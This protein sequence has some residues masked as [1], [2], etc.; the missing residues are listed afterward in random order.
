MKRSSTTDREVPRRSHRLR[1]AIIGTAAGLLLG[2]LL[3]LGLFT[4][5][6]SYWRSGP[7]IDGSDPAVAQRA[8]Q[9]EQ[10]LSSQTT[11]VRSDY[12]RWQIELTEEEVNEWLAARLPEWMRN[13]GIDERAVQ[14]AQ[15]A[16]VNVKPGQVELATVV[17]LGKF[18]PVVRLVYKPELNEAGRVQLSLD[19]IYA[20][21]MPLPGDSLIDEVL[22]Q[23]GPLEEEQ[24]RRVD[25]AR[26]TLRD[27][28][29]VLHLGDGRVVSVVGMELREGKVSL[30]CITAPTAV[31]S[32]GT[33]DLD[34]DSG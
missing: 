11:A 9:F 31:R 1:R 22:D 14:H 29:M 2:G 28:D 34:A 18:E 13:Q 19:T 17:R 12:Q 27:L 6:P 3:L 15:R 25:H 10:K 21:L 8:Q 20:G 4:A 33:V 23:F 30:V 5:A 7:A 26:K 32:D 24:Q 16:M